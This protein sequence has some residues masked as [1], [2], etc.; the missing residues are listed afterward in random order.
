MIIVTKKCHEAVFLI[1]S[2]PIGFIDYK[3]KQ[4]YKFSQL[5]FIFFYIFSY[6]K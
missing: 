5:F 3:Y 4:F 6:R 1:H 2:L